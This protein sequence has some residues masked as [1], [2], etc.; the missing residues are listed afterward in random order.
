VTATTPDLLPHLAG[1][2][3]SAPHLRTLAPLWDWLGEFGTEADWCAVLD[4]HP[5]HHDARARFALWLR[6]RGDERADG[7][8]ALAACGLRSFGS[9]RRVWVWFSERYYGRHQ[10]RPC[11]LPGDWYEKLGRIALNYEDWPTRAAAE[12]A[13]ALAF[14]KLPADRRARLLRGEM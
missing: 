8:A 5:D 14:L 2:T 7:Y 3:G 11:G 10:T 13:A 9:K 4:A 12:D 6:D 1:Y